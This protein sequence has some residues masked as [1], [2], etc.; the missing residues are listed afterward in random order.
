MNILSSLVFTAASP[1]SFLG[2]IVILAFVS[3]KALI[4]ASSFL[5][6]FIASIPAFLAAATLSQF[7]VV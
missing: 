5:A 4:T 2:I 6:A 7:L 3:V 1:I